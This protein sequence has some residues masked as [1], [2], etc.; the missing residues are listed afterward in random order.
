MSRATFSTV[1]RSLLCISAPVACHM[2]DHDYTMWKDWLVSKRTWNESRAL[3][4]V[5]IYK[6]PRVAWLRM[7]HRSDC[8]DLTYTPHHKTL[9]IALPSRGIMVGD[10][11]LL[12]ALHACATSDAVWWGWSVRSTPHYWKQYQSSDSLRFEACRMHVDHSGDSWNWWLQTLQT[13]AGKER[14]AGPVCM[15]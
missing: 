14:F 7:L 12:C 3:F 15:W 1:W 9:N 13:S 8:Y 4:Q 2:S 10:T 5:F 11:G 6:F